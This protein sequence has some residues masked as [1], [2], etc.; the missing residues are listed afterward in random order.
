LALTRINRYGR[1]LPFKNYMGCKRLD[2]KV[3][4]VKEEGKEEESRKTC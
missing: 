2:E 3:F 1:L 4:T